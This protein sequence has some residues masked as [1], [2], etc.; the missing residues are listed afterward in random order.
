MSGDADPGNRRAGDGPPS[1]RPERPHRQ[2]HTPIWTEPEPGARR[3]T[4]SRE[5][6]ATKAIEIADAEGYEAVSMRRVAAELGAGTM[7]LYHYVRTKADLIALMDDAAMAEVLVPDDELPDDWREAMAMIARRSREAWRAHPWTFEAERETVSFGPN[8]MRH[9]EQSL[10]AVAGTG[11][12]ERGRLEL[13][14]M[15]DDYVYGFV[16]RERGDGWIAEGE[17]WPEGL[18]ELVDAEARSGRHPQLERFVG[19]GGTRAALERLRE[20]MTGSDRFERGLARLLGGI[21]LDV[22]RSAR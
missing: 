8:G 12:D 7:T 3:T 15:V 11:L 22:E 10:A 9:F 16:M 20:L 18:I 13:L 21:A 17:P 2:A 14:M 5:L 19:E 4:L 1:P 6:I